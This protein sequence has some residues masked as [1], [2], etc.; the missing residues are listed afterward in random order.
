[1]ASVLNNQLKL[2][3]DVQ[4]CTWVIPALMSAH[5]E[6]WCP[7]QEFC[8]GDSSKHHVCVAPGLCL[9]SRWS[10]HERPK[11]SSGGR[12]LASTSA[13]GGIPAVLWGGGQRG[14]ATRP[15]PLV[16]TVLT[17]WGAALGSVDFT[18]RWV[19][20]ACRRS[21]SFA[22]WWEEKT[23][24]CHQIQMCDSFEHPKLWMSQLTTA[25]Q[26]IIFIASSSETYRTPAKVQVTGGVDVRFPNTRCIRL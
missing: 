10:P 2:L 4:Q 22:S 7:R 12:A 23:L 18:C 15:F 20:M 21:L 3:G 11:E 26:H 9:A 14:N 17:G 1:M 16:G 19:I 8:K 13:L 5:G 6:E 24:L 25:P